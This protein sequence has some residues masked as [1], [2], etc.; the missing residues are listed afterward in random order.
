LGLANLGLANLGLA[1]LMLTNLGLTNSAE[2]PRSNEKMKS[3]WV[4][5]GAMLAVLVTMTAAVAAEPEPPPGSSAAC[6]KTALAL[7]GAIDGGETATPQY[8]KAFATFVATCGRRF[9]LPRPASRRFRYL[10]CRDKISALVD[11][12]D[13]GQIKSGAFA[14]ARNAF[15]K[16]CAPH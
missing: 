6:H 1:N 12:I 15:A 2:K 4:V 3:A 14:R 16:M 7:I 11:L 13:N 9:V 8:G 5:M 10:S